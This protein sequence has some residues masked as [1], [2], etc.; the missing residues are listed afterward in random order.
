MKNSKKKFKKRIQKK[1]S[2]NNSKK[3]KSKKQ[4]GRQTH[5]SDFIG[6]LRKSRVSKSVK[7][8]KK[9][10]FILEYLISTPAYT[11]MVQI[12]AGTN[13]REFFQI[14]RN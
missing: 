8:G 9:E 11:L 7:T 1:N 10:A 14:S 4:T 13:F 5:K 12:F 6:P 3:K 2:K